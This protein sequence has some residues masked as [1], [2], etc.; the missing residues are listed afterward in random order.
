MSFLDFK[1]KPGEI[2]FYSESPRWILKLHRVTETRVLHP[3]GAFRLRRAYQMER[4]LIAI[5]LLFYDH[6]TPLY[7]SDVVALLS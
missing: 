2:S 6:Y 4:F 3:I 1:I 7:V 5:P